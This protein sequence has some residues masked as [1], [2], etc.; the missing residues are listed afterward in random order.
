MCVFLS[1]LIFLSDVVDLAN[2][3]I[4]DSGQIEKDAVVVDG[5]IDPMIDDE[6]KNFEITSLLLHEANASDNF[7]LI[8]DAQFDLR[9]LHIF[10]CSPL[11]FK[12][13]MR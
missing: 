8:T 4:I 13:E 5:V 11:V 12:L 6:A 3:R 1:L 9:F 2:G 7:L 10:L